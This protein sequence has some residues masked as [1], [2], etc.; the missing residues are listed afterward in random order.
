MKEKYSSYYINIPRVMQFIFWNKYYIIVLA[1]STFAETFLWFLG[2]FMICLFCNST[3][4]GTIF[5]RETT[6]FIDYQ[7]LS[8][9]SSLSY[10]TNN[11]IYFIL[12]PWFPINPVYIISS[13]SCT[14]I[15][16]KF[17]LL[18]IYIQT[19]SRILEYNQK[20]N[21]LHHGQRAVILDSY[22][23][24]ICSKFCG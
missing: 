19:H 16:V 17:Q 2:S 12:L 20:R 11:N 22:S 1:S 6:L 9:V 23:I 3:L 21:F 14:P 13:E 10:G 7:Q 8:I 15:A 5:I 24:D 18:T 4:F